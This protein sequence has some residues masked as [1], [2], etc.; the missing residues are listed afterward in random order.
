M[1]SESSK[2]SW[3]LRDVELGLLLE[4]SHAELDELVIEI[5][6]TEMGVTVSGLNLEDTL[7][8][9]E[10]GDIEST[11]SKIEDEDVLLTLGSLV[12][13]VSNGG[14][15][16][17]VDDS[18]DIKSSNSSGILGGLSLSIVEIGWA[19]NN[20]GFDGLTEILLSDF[21]HLNQNHG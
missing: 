4:F 11:T 7:V 8:N 5:F 14:G 3:V 15:S 17:L 19:S 9:G 6:S 20:S 12:K 16:W 13:T 2:S 1:G 10:D 21:L 18:K